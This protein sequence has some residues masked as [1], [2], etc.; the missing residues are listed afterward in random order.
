MKNLKNR[1][2]LAL[3]LA[4]GALTPLAAMESDSFDQD[5]NDFVELW[6]QEIN[7]TYYDQTKCCICLEEFKPEDTT[8]NLP[9]KHKYHRN[10]LFDYALNGINS[11]L[12][13]QCKKPYT[14]DVFYTNKQFKK[15]LEDISPN[16]KDF[17]TSKNLFLPEFDCK[18]FEQQPSMVAQ[19]CSQHEL[20]ALPDYE[21][22]SLFVRYKDLYLQNSPLISHKTAKK[23][24]VALAWQTAR[25]YFASL[26][27]G[28]VNSAIWITPLDRYFSTEHRPIL[29]TWTAAF[30]FLTSTASWVF[31]ARDYQLGSIGD[32]RKVYNDTAIQGTSDWNAACQDPYFMYKTK[33]WIFGH[34]A[35]PL[36]VGYVIV[37]QKKLK[38]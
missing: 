33:P 34:I 27:E 2:F 15:F 12:C 8:L 23:F 20:S 28:W 10:C 11:N 38:I 3:I 36:V 7:T 16:Q 6:D 35:F 14:F 31:K 9:C 22:Q 25:R 29:I 5:Y 21:Q 26:V 30:G 17:L 32:E 1:L 4:L 19:L 24:E 18:K 37:T 13:P